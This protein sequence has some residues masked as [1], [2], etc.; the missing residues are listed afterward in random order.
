MTVDTSHFAPSGPGLPAALRITHRGGLA[1]WQVRQATRQLADRIGSGVSV[2]AL[3]RQVRL[4]SSHFCRA[5]KASVGMPPHAYLIRLRIERAS[6]MMLETSDSLSQIAVACGF[7]DQAHLSRVFLRS[8]GSTPS[9]WRRT[10]RRA[11]LS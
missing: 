9:A 4:S 3:A 11:R 10:Q 5:F 6:A 7:P 2:A 8:V 1:P